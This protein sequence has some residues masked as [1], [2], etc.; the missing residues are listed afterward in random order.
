[1]SETETQAVATTAAPKA[2]KKARK[3]AKAQKAKSAPKASANG[4]LHKPERQVLRTLVKAAG[5][6]SRREIARRVEKQDA[7]VNGRIAAETKTYEGLEKKGL[8]RVKDLDIDGKNETVNEITAA[9]KKAFA[10]SK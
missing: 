9:G 10:E 2:T 8:I 1:M 3:S 4:K 5:P 6:L 7:L